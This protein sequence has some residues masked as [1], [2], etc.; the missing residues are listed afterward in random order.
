[1]FDGKKRQGA[2]GAWA[3]AVL[4]V[5]DFRLDIGSAGHLCLGALAKGYMPLGRDLAQLLATLA[6]TRQNSSFNLGYYTS[7]QRLVQD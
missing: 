6:T 5:P 4:F 3:L 1:M 7:L 2:N